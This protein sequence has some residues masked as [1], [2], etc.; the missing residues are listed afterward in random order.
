MEISINV[1]SSLDSWPNVCL[2]NRNNSFKLK[3]T[4]KK[5][6]IIIIIMVITAEV[7]I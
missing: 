1:S 7:I 4:H 6:S 2:N 3:F 5:V